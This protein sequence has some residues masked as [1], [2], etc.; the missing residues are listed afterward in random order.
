ML[1]PAGQERTLAERRLAIAFARDH[2]YHLRIP[3]MIRILLALGL[4]ACLV[5]AA[6]SGDP[7]S[8][9]PTGDDRE[10]VAASASDPV[11]VGAGDIGDCKSSGDEITAGLLDDID[12]TVF[13]LGDNAYPKGTST[14]FS[15]CYAPSWG[16][17]KARTRP[18]PGNHDYATPGAGP[19]YS[20][21]GSRAGPSGKGYY[22]YDLGV[23]HI[24]SLNSNIKAGSSSKQAKWLRSDLAANPADCTL[25]YWHHAVFSSGKHGPY[26]PKMANLWR[27]LD[28]AGVDVVLAAHDHIYERFAP[29]DANG[30]ANQDGIRQFV[31]GTGGGETLYAFEA[32]P[33]N[34]EIRDNSARGVLKLTLRPGGYD[35]EFVPQ[36][37]KTFT[38]TGS[39]ACVEVSG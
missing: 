37:G 34:S 22:S 21:F 5:M 19:Y 35:W 12:G 28:E 29:Q 36:P 39:A 20:Y 8:S 30:Q 18:S 13:T 17:H 2:D 27:I 11:F 24:I 32:N 38:D 10:Q 7:T 33:A 23:W 15:N 1:Q 26:T 14:Q 6:C 3:M 31:V 25:A 4:P 16:R 9:E